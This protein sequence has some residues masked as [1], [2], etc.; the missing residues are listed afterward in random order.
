MNAAQVIHLLSTAPF[1]IKAF[2]WYMRTTS[3][4]RQE[5]AEEPLQDSAGPCRSRPSPGLLLQVWPPSP[6]VSANN[7]PAQ[8]HLPSQDPQPTSHLNWCSRELRI[9]EEKRSASFSRLREY[10]SSISAFLRKNSC[11]S[12]NSC[13]RDS[14]CCSRHLNCST[15]CVRISVG[16]KDLTIRQWHWTAV[17]HT[18][19]SPARAPVL[20]Y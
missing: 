11:K 6:I 12:C 9:L 15:S 8:G 18:P 5:E 13:S 19:Q 3:S 20:P 2:T 4:W 14:D 16:G 17:T 1:C 10:S 7:P